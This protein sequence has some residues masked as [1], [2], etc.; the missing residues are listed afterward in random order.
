MP[1]ARPR[2][3]HSAAYMAIDAAT[4][5]SLELLD[6]QR[7][8]QRARCAT[9]SIS[10]SRP[11][12]RGCW[13]AGSPRRCAMR[14]PS[15]RGSTRWRRSLADTILTSRLRRR[16][17]SVPDLTRALT[18]LAL[19]RGGPRDLRAI[20]A[21]RRRR[22]AELAARLGAPRRRAG[23]P[24][25]HLGDDAR[26]GAT[27]AGRH[28]CSPRIDDEPPLLARDG[29]FVAQ[30]LRHAARCRA[31]ARLRDPRRRR[32]A[33]GP[34]DRRDRRQVAEDPPQWRARLFRRSA[35]GAWRQA[36][37]GAAPRRPSSIARPWP[38]PCASPPRNWPNS[39]A[40]SPA[41]MRPRSRS[42][43]AS[44][45]RLRAAVL[46][47]TDALRAIADALA[48]L[49]VTAALAHLAATRSYCRPEID[50][51]LAFAI[52]ARPPSGGRDNRSRPP[53]RALSRMT[54]ISSERR[55]LAGH[56]PQHGRQVDLPAPERAD[57]HPGADGQLRAGSAGPYRRR[58]PRVL[59]R[60]RQRRYRPWP[61][62]LHG[63]NG[64][65][66]RHSQPRHRRARWSSST[67]SGAARRPSM[68]CRSPG[69][70]VE[71]LHDDTGCRALFATH[72]HEMTSL[73][74]TLEP[75]LQS[76]HEGAR[77]GGRGG[78]PA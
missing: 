42:R 34:A 49:D 40:A 15:T 60:R 56:R 33:A 11:P 29:G 2:P 52:E 65:N 69:P 26:R 5:S 4:R 17:K 39:R 37:G 75:R 36:A 43:R 70:A 74:K 71:A 22:R 45:P 62:D 55:A 35:S 30:G 27:A 7:G 16:L 8:T 66:R 3:K 77:M 64:R 47:E 13:P 12:A 59:A 44:S 23:R 38:T 58:R 14:Q 20:A 6:T 67:R 73:A 46:A 32:R 53:A 50:D 78:V 51:S 28:D 9:R 57:R 19:D 41:P 63:R 24:R 18:R 54:A 10:A 25:P 61:L 68:V 48:A 76:H 21:R 72:F 31:G 1:C